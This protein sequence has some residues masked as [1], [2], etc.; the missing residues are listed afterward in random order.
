MQQYPMNQQGFYNAPQGQA[1]AQPAAPL[2]PQ[3]PFM[4]QVQ[5]M[6]PSFPAM[7]QNMFPVATP[8]GMQYMQM[9]GQNKR[10]RQ[11]DRNNN[12]GRRNNGGNNGGLS[13][14]V[15]GLTQIVSNQVMA[16]EQSR[17]AALAEEA[18]RH[19]AAEKKKDAEDLQAGILSAVKT[20]MAKTDAAVAHVLS[21]LNVANMP[22]SLTSQ[23]QHQ[24]QPAAPLP[25]PQTMQ[26]QAVAPPPP[27]QQYAPPQ[28]AQQCAQL[29]QAPP[30]PPPPLQQQPVNGATPAVTR[31][32]LNAILYPQGQARPKGKAKAKARAR[33]QTVEQV[34][35]TL[36]NRQLSEQEQDHIMDELDCVGLDKNDIPDNLF[37][38][39]VSELDIPDFGNIAE[40][41][42]MY[43]DAFGERPQA[44]FL[45]KELIARLAAKALGA[46]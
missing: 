44:R 19:A 28:Y 2:V 46:I 7:G 42:T 12:D 1:F 29:Q 13:D 36:A 41:R 9:P 26:H 8:M 3:Q 22:A 32:N 18:S 11:N 17:Q 35:V 4:N 21:N 23:Q 45:R 20:E 25:P 15:A 40:W 16:Q 39:L 30:P 31:Q 27:P 6:P 10:Q 43:E 34:L 14:A 33:V 5:Q 37:Y 38:S 24:Q